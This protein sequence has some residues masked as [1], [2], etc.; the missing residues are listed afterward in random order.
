MPWLQFDLLDVI[1]QN[2]K[3]GRQS[4]VYQTWCCVHVPFGGSVPGTYCSKCSDTKFK[5][6]F[7]ISYLGE[8][9]AFENGP[10]YSHAKDAL[11]LWPPF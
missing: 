11:W 10:C 4:I 5:D 1:V 3:G 9:V 6:V 8:R 7:E 2:T